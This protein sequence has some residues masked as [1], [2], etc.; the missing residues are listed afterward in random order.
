MIISCSA[1]PNSL[2]RRLSTFWICILDPENPPSQPETKEGWQRVHLRN[3]SQE[4]WKCP[5]TPLFIHFL[6]CYRWPISVGHPF[7]VL[8][9]WCMV[10]IPGTIFMSH[11]R[12]REPSFPRMHLCPPRTRQPHH[13]QPCVLQAANPAL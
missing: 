1:S 11:L 6:H 2:A 8:I 5:A 12:C 3:Q 7:H 9:S 13:T 10:S 4:H